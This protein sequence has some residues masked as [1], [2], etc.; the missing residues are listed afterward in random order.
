MTTTT[1][2]RAAAVR[3]AVTGAGGVL[4]RGLAARLLSQGHDVV[5]IARHRPESWPSA[6]DF[7]RSRHPRRRRGQTRRR[8]R[9][10]RRA[11]RM[12]EDS[13][14]RQRS[15]P[16]QHRRDRATSLDAMAETGS[17]RIVFASSAHVYGA[18]RADRP[19]TRPRTRI[20]PKA[21]S[22]PGSNRCS[23]HRRRMGRDPLCADPG[24]RRRQLGA[25]TAGATGVP[26]DGSA[27]R[28]MQVVHLDD[29][30]RLFVRAR[31]GCRN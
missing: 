26:V 6:A 24:P 11:L 22:K 8:R 17:R 10:R 28:R 27:D 18:R 29:A 2:D 7:R 21:G 9:G 12:G 31:P 5:G 30:L 16:D 25:P 23:R 3:I 14:T 13:R 1:I 20:M 19:S 4:G 15:P